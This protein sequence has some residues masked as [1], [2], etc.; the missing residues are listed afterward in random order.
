MKKKIFCL[1]SALLLMM[2]AMPIMAAEE[3]TMLVDNYL[4]TF[5]DIDG[6]EVTTQSNGKPKLV[7]IGR[8]SCRER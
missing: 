1:L 2:Q 8:A 6:T 3:D 7:E 4:Y 5:T